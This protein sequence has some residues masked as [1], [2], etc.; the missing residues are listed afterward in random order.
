MSPQFQERFQAT[1]FSQEKPAAY[2]DDDN[3]RNNRKYTVNPQM[4]N[5]FNQMEKL[6]NSKNLTLIIDRLN[7]LKK[8]K[9]QLAKYRREFNQKLDTLQSTSENTRLKEEVAKLKQKTQSQQSIMNVNDLAD[10][11]VKIRDARTSNQQKEKYLQEYEKRILNQQTRYKQIQTAFQKLTLQ[12]G[13]QNQK[14]SKIVRYSLLFAYSCLLLMTILTI[15]T[16]ISENKKRH[17]FGFNYITDKVVFGLSF[18]ALI[19]YLYH[20]NIK[21]H[22]LDLNVITILYTLILILLILIHRKK[23]KEEEFTE[24]DNKKFTIALSIKLGLICLLFLY[25]LISSQM[26]KDYIMNSFIVQVKTKVRTQLTTSI[27]MMITTVIGI[28]GANTLQYLK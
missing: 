2:D 24:E 17:L 9:N 25:L 20:I 15:V 8:D 18:V 26:Y 23:K 6:K 16:L 1:T 13:V 4:K 22:M 11:E 14:R 28:I 10:I 3:N 19:V 5:V 27:A 12:N 7:S 21:T